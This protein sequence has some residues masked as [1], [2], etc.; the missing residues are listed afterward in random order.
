MQSELSI[1]IAATID[2][3]EKVAGE[4]AVVAGGDYDGSKSGE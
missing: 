3:T 1:E 2:R 4:T